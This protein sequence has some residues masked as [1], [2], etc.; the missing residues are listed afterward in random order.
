M[1]AGVSERVSESEREGGFVA[2]DIFEK[3][4]HIHAFTHSHP[5]GGGGAA[6]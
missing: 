1:H 6:Y 3:D 5:A 4:T 2:A